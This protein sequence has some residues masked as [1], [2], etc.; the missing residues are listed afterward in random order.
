MISIRLI[1]LFNTR[2]HSSR[3]KD[4]PLPSSPG[5]ID[6]RALDLRIDGHAAKR[7]RGRF[8][9]HRRG[10]EDSHG[11]Q[12]VVALGNKLD[13]TSFEP[14]PSNVILVDS[15]PQLELLPR[16]S[17]CITH[18]GLNTVLEALTNKLPLVALPV[19]NDQ[20]GVAARIKALG[21]GEYLG[22]SEIT[23]ETLLSAV[24]KVLTESS[25]CQNAVKIGDRLKEANGLCLAADLLERAFNA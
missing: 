6:R 8:P 14:L 4:E 18:A 12:F 25:Y 5:L 15:A 3:R 1:P 11:I 17:L 20:P 21:V 23:A 13:P 10:S 19:T 24:Q 2:V 7:S 9:S 22:M 16:A